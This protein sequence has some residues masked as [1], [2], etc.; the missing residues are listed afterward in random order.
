[1]IMV[2]LKA[3]LFG[4]KPS[5]L[6]AETLVVD[7]HALKEV[8]SLLACAAEVRLSG[9]LESGHGYELAFTLVVLSE[10]PFKLLP[11]LLGLPGRQVRLW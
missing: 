4:L 9:H 3:P 1:M 6:C 11:V 8:D 2:I 10:P 5:G 7:F